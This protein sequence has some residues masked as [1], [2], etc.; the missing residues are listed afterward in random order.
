MSN[1]SQ[2]TSASSIGI[3]K[4]YMEE[5]MRREF[6]SHRDRFRS[7]FIRQ[8]ADAKCIEECHKLQLS[9]DFIESLKRDAKIN[10]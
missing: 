1:T 10:S 9:T 8:D 3:D 5:V 7:D 2:M 4:E 6:D